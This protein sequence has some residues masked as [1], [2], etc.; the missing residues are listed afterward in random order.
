MKI[1]KEKTGDRGV[2]FLF[3][4]DTKEILGYVVLF[5][6]LTEVKCLE[7]Q[8]RQQEKLAAVGQL[9]AG[10][11]H[12]IRNPLASISG[13]VQMLESSLLELMTMINV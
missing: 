7:F 5:Q 1:I 4:G 8:M 6:D 10:I 12:E 9:A 13:S 3:C 11:A 2:P